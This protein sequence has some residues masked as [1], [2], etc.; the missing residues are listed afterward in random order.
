M[1]LWLLSALK[2]SPRK[3]RRH[4]PKLQNTTFPQDFVLAGKTVFFYQIDG[5]ASRHPP[6]F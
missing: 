1:M 5:N 2:I 4:L 6:R 3:V